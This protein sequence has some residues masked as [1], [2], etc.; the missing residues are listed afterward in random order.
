MF[1]YVHIT[2]KQRHR[3]VP[4]VVLG[5]VKLNITNLMKMGRPT[6]DWHKLMPIN[7]KTASKIPIPQNNINLGSI[8]LEMVWSDDKVNNAVEARRRQSASI[9]IQCHARKKFANIISSNLKDILHG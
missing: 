6:K 8:L 7:T 4:D 3:F 5:K 1:F 9:V 2:L